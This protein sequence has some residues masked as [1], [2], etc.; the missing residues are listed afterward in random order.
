MIGDRVKEYRKKRNMTQRQLAAVTNISQ[1]RISQLESGEI[2]EIESRRLRA[3]A[4]ALHVSADILLELELE[5]I[6]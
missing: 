5:P 1:G 2:T 4:R 3:L 6:S